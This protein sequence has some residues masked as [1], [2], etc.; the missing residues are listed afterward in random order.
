MDAVTAS[1]YIDD[2]MGGVKGATIK[3]DGTPE[4]LSAL[5]G[6]KAARSG[7]APLV[8]LRGKTLNVSGIPGDNVQ[9]RVVNM[10]G[11]RVAN[12]SAR[13]GASLSL[14]KL[15]AGAYIVEAKA[16]GRRVTQSVV[17]R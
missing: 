5:P 6:K 3:P 11:R 10:A 17:L 12:F 9:I 4:L 14:R 15:P 1:F 16:G 2:A 7:Y 13:G 8:T